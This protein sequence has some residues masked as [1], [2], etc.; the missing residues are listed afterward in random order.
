MKK[1][2]DKPLDAGKLRLR[3]EER[4]QRR[5]PARAAQ[6]TP[7]DAAR[8]VHELQVH[9]IEL[10]MQNEELQ[11]E[12]ARVEV[13]AARYTEL[14]DFAPVGYFSLDREG[15]IR[16]ANLRG[17]RLLGLDRSN[18]MQQRFGL[19]VAESDRP[20]F[21]AFLQKEFAGAGAQS[22][23][24]GLCKGGDASMWVRIEATASED[25]QECRAVVLDLSERRQAEAQA[26]AAVV[27]T[28]RLL[29]LSERSRR[30]LLSAAEDQEAATRA[31]RDSEQ[32]FRGLVEQSLTGI[33][34][35]QDGAFLYANPRLE[36]VLGYRPGE[37][38][39]VRA[40]DIVIAEDLPIMQAK[41]EALRAGATTSNYEVRARR[42]DGAIIELGV[43]GRVLE[44]RGVK[45]TIG[46]AQDITEKK[47]AEEEIQRHIARLKAAFAG[48]VD[49]TMRMSEMRDPYTAGHERRVSEIAAA[50]GAEL[51]LEAQATEGLRVAG[52]LHDVGKIAVPAEILAKPG[53]LSAI[54]LRLIRE[55][56]QAGY[57]VL[58]G[59]E[60]PWP[61]AQ[62]ALQHHERMD[63]SGYPQGLKG[64]A[65]LLEARIMAVADVVE[66]MS[67]HRP[68]RPGLGIG[69]A[70]AEI[71]RG[72]GTA[73]DPAVADA[74]LKLFREK[75]YALPA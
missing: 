51:G 64:E 47:R 31:L 56:P 18:L 12:R 34:I 48:T 69:K 54:E 1:S 17:A 65:I 49:V 6:P 21:S 72:R 32:R 75:E 42:K 70:L 23:E 52:Q 50:I 20:A 55:H 25:G 61:V 38:V 39:G 22:C 9:Q 15:V 27:E 60:F 7:I 40:D 66:A 4:L 30:A 59:V 10:E 41:R 8:L 63:G 67:S 2:P 14:Y 46:M 5:R 53:K 57:D 24:L 43:Q 73:Y 74:C 37:L 35:S 71:E 29:A 13:L 28:Q 16:Q 11:Q 62:V 68:Y 58:A 3:A 44:S 33:Y 26:R 19:F 36:E 45:T